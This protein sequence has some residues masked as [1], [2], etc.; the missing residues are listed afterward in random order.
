MKILSVAHS[1]LQENA[2]HAGGNTYSFYMKQIANCPDMDLHVIC[3]GKPGD[4]SKVDFSKFGA[5]GTILMRKGSLLFNI[6]RVLWDM[7]GRLFGKSQIN[8]YFKHRSYI[9]ALTKLK[10]NGYYP[11]VIILEWTECVSL[12]H[13]CREIFPDAHI[14]GSEHDV[15]FLSYERRA[16][17]SANG[18]KKKRLEKKASIIKQAELDAIRN[19][20]VVMPHNLKD[21]MLLKKNGIPDS[22]IF[23][24]VAFYSSKV[25]IAYHPE[26]HDIIFWGAMSRPENYEAAEWFIEKV[27]PKLDDTDV[28]FIVIGSNP[29]PSLVQLASDKVIITGFV[30]KPDDYFKKSLCMVVPLKVGAGIKVKV[31]EAMSSGIPVLTNEIGIEGI[32]ARD[33]VEYLYCNSAD[34]YN[35]RIRDLIAGNIDPLSMSTAERRLIEQNFNLEESASSYI[36][37]LRGLIS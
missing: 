3:M 5:T 35:K 13:V 31:L 33:N 15:L 22:M 36:R 32:P 10:N 20:D 34:S 21:A 27:M 28:R 26:N 6:R 23:P 17:N 4:S 7:Y 19:C 12:S 18:P 8:S 29:H 11:N 25:H 16:A 30:D 37:M 9:K 14:L 24:I 2:P 1:I